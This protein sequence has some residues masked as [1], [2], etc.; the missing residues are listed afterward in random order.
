MQISNSIKKN[1]IKFC[2]EKAFNGRECRSYCRFT[3]KNLLFLKRHKKNLSGCRKNQSQ[4]LLVALVL[5]VS[6]LFHMNIVGSGLLNGTESS[7]FPHA[8][9]LQKLIKILEMCMY[10]STLLNW[11]SSFFLS[12]HF[13]DGHLTYKMGKYLHK[14]ALWRKPKDFNIDQ[15]SFS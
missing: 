15:Q 7:S 11:Y 1:I 2:S 8:G 9:S 13:Q 3:K 12:L 6:K 10:F 5:S 4:K 14:M